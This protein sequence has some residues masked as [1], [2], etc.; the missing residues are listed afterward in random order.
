[1]QLDLILLVV[2]QF[3]FFFSVFEPVCNQFFL[4]RKKVF[5]HYVGDCGLSTLTWTTVYGCAKWLTPP[6]CHLDQELWGTCS[7][8]VA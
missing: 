1:M 8:M 6:I 4:Y 5:Y 7:F 3:G 2:H